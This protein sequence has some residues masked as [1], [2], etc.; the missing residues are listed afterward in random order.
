MADYVIVLDPGHGS[1]QYHGGEFGPY[2]EKDID[3]AVALT[4]KDHLEKYEGVKVYLTR[5]DDRVVELKER[6]DIAKA[7][8][9]DYFISVHFNMSAAHDLYGSEVWLPVQNKYY[10]AMYPMAN[11]FMNTFRSMGLFDRGIKTRLSSSGKDNYYAVLK[12]A[13][14][15]GI[16]SCIVEHCH[17]DNINDT[18]LLPVVNQATYSAALTNFGIQ[19]A[20]AIARTL[21]LKSQILGT[22]YSNYKTVKGNAKAALIKMDET[23]PEVNKVELVSKD[24]QANTVTIKLTAKDKNSYLLYYKYS[25]D[26]GITFSEALEWPS[27]GLHNSKESFT[28]TINV[29][30]NKELNIVTMV[31]NSYDVTTLSNVLNV[32]ALGNVNV[33]TIKELPINTKEDNVSISIVEHD[34]NI[35]TSNLVNSMEYNTMKKTSGTYSYLLVDGLITCTVIMGVLIK[36]VLKR[37]LNKHV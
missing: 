2:V 31:Y 22:D 29:P 15:Y 24:T 1:D 32:P 20:E 6:A 9:A 4:I 30:A 7:Y 37:L 11:E 27:Y 28:T 36:I 8:N 14:N 10:N 5:Y 33:S 21:K 35:R 19:D 12:Y 3:L 25:I 34:N 26:G 18:K 13:T 16:P 17:M 23:A